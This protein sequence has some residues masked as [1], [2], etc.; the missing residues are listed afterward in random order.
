MTRRHLL[1][2]VAGLAIAALFVLVLTRAP[3]GAFSALETA[4]PLPVAAG[5]VLYAV[6]F[7]ARAV[8]LNALLPRED[9]LPFGRALSLSAAATFLLQVI[10]FRGGEVA[11]W[12]AYRRALGSG[13]L[14]AGAVFA[15]VKAVDTAT[16]LLVGLAGGAVLGTRRG[17]PVLGGTAALLVLAGAAALLLAPA[18]GTRLLG[19]LSPRLPAGSRRR[20]AVDELAA[21][22]SVAHARPVL[23]ALSVGASLLFLV[24]HVAAIL[25]VLTG[26]GARATAAGVAFASLT[27]T[28]VAALL[29]SPAGTFG[30]MESGFAGGLSADGIPVPLGFVAAAIV[31]LL[32]TAAA[33]LAGLP[34]L[35][36]GRRD[37]NPAP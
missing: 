24:G 1:G 16:L 15:L 4:R 9:R 23:F 32:T 10:P 37:S 35:L 33:G 27:G 17:A 20:R 21:G 25:L 6:S 29:P 5:F 8:R 28:G 14:R 2:V 12:A 19:S 7:A 36:A 11:S 18:I 31:H 34:F 13:W 22:L 30:P 26:L 3:A